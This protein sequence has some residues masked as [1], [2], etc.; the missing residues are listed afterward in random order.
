[1]GRHLSGEGSAVVATGSWS[2]RRVLRLVGLT[3]LHSTTYH[4]GAPSF[5]PVVPNFDSFEYRLPQ[6]AMHPVRLQIPPTTTNHRKGCRNF[7]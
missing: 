7:E 2:N 1:M 4:G 5:I 6:I 3:R